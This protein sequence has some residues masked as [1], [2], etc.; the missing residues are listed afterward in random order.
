MGLVLII[1]NDLSLTSKHQPATTKN[2]SSGA[3][4]L[5]GRPL[6]DSSSYLTPLIEIEAKNG[7]FSCTRGLRVMEMGQYSPPGP[8]DLVGGPLV[9]PSPELMPST[10]IKAEG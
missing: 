5:V 6:V 9:D 7:C 4:N 8:N 1:G 10:E 3:S 2:P